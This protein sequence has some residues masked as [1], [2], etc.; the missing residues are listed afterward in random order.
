MDN[1]SDYLIGPFYKAFLPILFGLKLWGLRYSKRK[2][3]EVGGK[4]YK[5]SQCYCYTVTLVA[6]LVAI[7]SFASLRLLKNIDSIMIFNLCISSFFVLTAINATMFL[8][9]SYDS[10]C[11][12]KFFLGFV[13]LYNFGGVFITSGKVKQI[14]LIATLICWIGIAMNI[15]ITSILTFRSTTFDTLSSD[16][17][18]DPATVCHL[19]M[20]STFVLL[21]TF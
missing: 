11:L 18:V 5:V 15:C 21:A 4:W 7:R 16:P 17:C 14:N 6:W 2:S 12:R 20:K 10:K 1:S 9:A 19:L 13:K 3:S 8:K